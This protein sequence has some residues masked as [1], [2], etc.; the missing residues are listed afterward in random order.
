MERWP[1]FFI[2]GAPKAGTSSLYAYLQRVPGVYMSRIKEPNFFSRAL[3]PDDHPVRPIRDK[4]AY[5]RLFA[6]ASE[7]QLVGEA[8]PTYL[9]DPEAIHLINEIVPEAR[10][11][12]SLR[13]PV[14]RAHSHYLMMVNNG[15]AG[16]SFLEE[17]ERGLR[18]RHQYGRM[19]LRPEIGLY[20]EQ[21]A[22]MWTVVPRHRTLIVIFKEFVAHPRRTMERILAFLGIEDSLE[23]FEPEVHRGYGVPKSALVRML[24]RN[25]TVSRLSELLIPPGARLAIRQKLLIKKED[26]PAIPHDA[27]ERLEELYAEDVK[28][29]SALLERPLPWPRFGFPSMAPESRPT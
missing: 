3:V 19:L 5:Q 12:V 18:Y 6:D 1:D 7:H 4:E 25:R 24:F 23:G 22:R 20:G 13:D 8:S 29:L 21:L 26:K 15:A 9:A 11:V 27:R 28:R 2:A 16:P 17:I 10:F 14:E